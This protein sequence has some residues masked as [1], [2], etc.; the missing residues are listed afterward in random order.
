MLYSGT[1]TSSSLSIKGSSQTFHFQILCHGLHQLTFQCQFQFPLQHHIIGSRQKYRYAYQVYFVERSSFIKRDLMAFSALF[2][3][4][5][6]AQICIRS[7]GLSGMRL[8]FVLV[9]QFCCMCLNELLLYYTP[10]PV[11]PEIHTIRYNR[12]QLRRTMLPIPNT[13]NQH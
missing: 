5:L 7:T 13:D 6:E 11:M 8:A 4:W 1:Q 2:A 12:S 9:S 3:I 10:F